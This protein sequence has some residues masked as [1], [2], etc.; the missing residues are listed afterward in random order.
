MK[1]WG[2]WGSWASEGGGGR[3]NNVWTDTPCKALSIWNAKTE[4]FF[5]FMR[6]VIAHIIENEMNVDGQI[7]RPKQMNG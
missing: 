6:L 4:K 5:T 3:H 2:G 7:R 1:G